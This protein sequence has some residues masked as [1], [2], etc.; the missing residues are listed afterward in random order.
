MNTETDFLLRRIQ[1]GEYI[2][3][4]EKKAVVGKKKWVLCLSD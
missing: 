3:N 2:I 1:Q 4:N